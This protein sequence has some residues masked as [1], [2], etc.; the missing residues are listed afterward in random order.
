V[1]GNYAAGNRFIGIEVGQG[2][3][4]IGNTANGNFI[5]IRVA[6]PANL[7]DNT[8]VNNQLINLLLNGEDCHSEDNL[9]P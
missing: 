8:A 3:T 2:S 5:G 1:T 7:T 9:A 4:V 6:C